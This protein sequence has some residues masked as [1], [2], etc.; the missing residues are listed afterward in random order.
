MRGGETVKALQMWGVFVALLGSVAFSTSVRA[1]EIKVDAYDRGYYIITGE[2]FSDFY[3]TFTGFTR[4]DIGRTEYRSFFVFSIPE[5]SI[6]VSAATLKLEVELYLGNAPI[7]NLR[8]VDVGTPNHYSSS[9]AR[10]RKRR[11]HFHL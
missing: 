4:D 5:Q 3:N 10:S 11:W 8:V 2:H 1:A 9:G 6:P 7:E